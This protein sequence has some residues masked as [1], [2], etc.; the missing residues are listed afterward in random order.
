MSLNNEIEEGKI[1]NSSVVVTGMLHG[2]C[3]RRSPAHEILSSNRLQ[4]DRASGTHSTQSAKRPIASEGTRPVHDAD[5]RPSQCFEHQE[6]AKG[7]QHEEM[8]VS[9]S[10]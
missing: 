5:S 8:Q 6:V 3:G 2:M 1:S 7:S 4:R 9:Y 10:L